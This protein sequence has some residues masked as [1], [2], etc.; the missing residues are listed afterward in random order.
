MSIFPN[1][2]DLILAIFSG[3][4]TLS[5]SL[6]FYIITQTNKDMKDAKRHI[7]ILSVSENEVPV[8]STNIITSDNEIRDATEYLNHII[9]YEIEKISDALQK[10]E[11]EKLQIQKTQGLFGL[12]GAI[13][14]FESLVFSLFYA[15]KGTKIFNETVI[16]AIDFLALFFFGIIILRLVFFSKKIKSAKNKMKSIFS[17]KSKALTLLSKSSKAHITTDS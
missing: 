13:F 2:Q 4:I 14:L 3:L 6:A 10:L 12:L 16:T 9:P 8:L 5:G 1:A 17:E 7:E 15:L 11:T